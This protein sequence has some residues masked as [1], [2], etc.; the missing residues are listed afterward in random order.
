MKKY[1]VGLIIDRFRK[2]IR[3][4]NWTA[5]KPGSSVSFVTG[6]TQTDN[7]RLKINSIYQTP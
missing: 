6:G 4:C 1:R 3:L 7:M 2:T 5:M